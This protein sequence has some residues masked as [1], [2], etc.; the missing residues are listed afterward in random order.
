MKKK[1]TY[2]LNPFGETQLG[3]RVYLKGLPTPKALAAAEETTKITLSISAKSL[4][5]FKQEAEKY[6]IPY[7]VMIRRLLDAY[8]SNLS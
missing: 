8:T 4:Q 3:K 7:Q 6:N 1:T 5:F 2:E